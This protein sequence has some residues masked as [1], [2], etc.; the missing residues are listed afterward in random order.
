MLSEKKSLPKKIMF[1]KDN[2]FTLLK[3]IKKS[4]LRIV[5]R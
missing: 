5:A 3:E 1:K 4:S 2:L